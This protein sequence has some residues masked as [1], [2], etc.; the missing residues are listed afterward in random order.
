MKT[1]KYRTVILKLKLL[2]KQTSWMDK[3]PNIM[4]AMSNQTY[5]HFV[6]LANIVIADCNL[7]HYR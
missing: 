6:K 4:K 3:Q 2:S 7:Q 5:I 1:L